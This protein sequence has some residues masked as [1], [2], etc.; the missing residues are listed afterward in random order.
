MRG[1][2]KRFTLKGE[3]L[4]LERKLESGLIYLNNERCVQKHPR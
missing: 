1:E 3:G 2:P 4:K